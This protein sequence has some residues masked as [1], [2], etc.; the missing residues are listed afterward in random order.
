[1]DRIRI[2]PADV[3]HVPFVAPM[4]RPEDLAEATALVGADGVEQAMR[5]SI[6]RSEWAFIAIEDRGPVALWGVSP[7]TVL[8]SSYAPWALFTVLAA[9]H[10][11]QIAR[12]S[13]RWVGLMKAQ[14]PLMR[15][16][17]DGRNAAAVRWL[18]WLGFEIG[19]PQPIGPARVPFHRFE[20]EG[21]N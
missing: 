12:E 14:F 9:D 5:D 4:L 8:G 2:I 15:N 1:M 7:M 3:E 13:R 10:R 11:R 19:E 21:R 20:M 6:E 18:S 17:V 16:I